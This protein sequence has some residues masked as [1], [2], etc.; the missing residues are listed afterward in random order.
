VQVAFMVRQFV[1][2]PVHRDPR[3]HRASPRHRSHN[4]KN[5]TRDHAGRKSAMREETMVADR[6]AEAREK[7]HTKKQADLNNADGAIKQQAQ[8]E[9]RTKKGQHIEEYEVTPLQLVKVTALDYSMIAHFESAIDSKIRKYH[10][11]RLPNPTLPR[12][13]GP[14]QAC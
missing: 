11:S 14:R 10:P 1:M 12:C 4:D 2:P 6:Q 5:A 9:E 3:Q 13:T 7:P 8:C